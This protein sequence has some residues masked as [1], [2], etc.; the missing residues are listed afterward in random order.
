MFKWIRRYAELHASK[1][2]VMV[3]DE[4]TREGS[5]NDYFW[6]LRDFLLR[7]RE[8]SWIS[9]GVSFYKQG[10]GTLANTKYKSTVEW[11]VT[12]SLHSLHSN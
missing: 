2:I 11:Y 4:T 8:Y 12:E 7:D 5:D 9:W 10:E 3:R 1:S 6:N